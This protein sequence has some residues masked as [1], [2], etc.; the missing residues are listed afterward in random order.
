LYISEA[1]YFLEVSFIIID[2]AFLNCGTNCFIKLV[3]SVV[4]QPYQSGNTHSQQL[5]D[6]AVIHTKQG[7]FGN[8]HNV[9][10]FNAVVEH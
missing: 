8:K 10:H 1:L 9:P 2:V 5:A 3:S 7:I 6:V 4:L